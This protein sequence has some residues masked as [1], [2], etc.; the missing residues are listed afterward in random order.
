M[1]QQDLITY[2]SGITLDS[3]LAD[4]PRIAEVMAEFAPPQ[5]E[6]NNP[7]V[8]LAAESAYNKNAFAYVCQLAG[9]IGENGPY[10]Y[11]DLVASQV[12]AAA[13]VEEGGTLERHFLNPHAS[14]RI[15]MM[16]VAMLRGGKD[17]QALARVDFA[18]DACLRMGDIYLWRSADLPQVGD[19]Y[20]ACMGAHFA[21]EYLAASH[22]FPGMVELFKAEQP[23][24]LE[25]LQSEKE[26]HFGFSAAD[27]IEG[28]PAVEVQHAQYACRAACTAAWRN[29]DASGFWADFET[30]FTE[31]C[32]ND[33]A[34][35]R[36]LSQVD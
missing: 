34:Y 15:W 14:L 36:N 11:R 13:S 27:W 28:H 12:L 25:Y 32:R 1:A 23:A 21:S 7:L 5:K 26:P 31:F 20:A 30:G 6:L 24:L 18:R 3:F 16:R 17:N 29:H 9:Q 35:F 10:P 4:H 22:E 2:I 19:R 33:Q 8:V